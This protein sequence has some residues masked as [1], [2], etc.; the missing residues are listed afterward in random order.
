MRRYGRLPVRETVRIPSGPSGILRCSVND[1]SVEMD[2][3]LG[4]VW[5]LFVSDY[6]RGYAFKRESPARLRALMIPR[7]LT[8]S[9]LH[10]NL[11]IRLMVGTPRW[12]SYLWRRLLI[13][14]HAC[15]V[16]RD[17][18]IGP[19][20]ELP[21]PF[22]I[23]IGGNTRIGANVCIHHGVSIGP[24]RGRWIPGTSGDADATVVIE[25]GVVLFPYSQILAVNKRIGA[26]AEVGALQ[27]V[28]DDLP[29]G[30]RV[31][32]AGVRLPKELRP[33]QGLPEPQVPQPRRP[34]PQH[35][36]PQPT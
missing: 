29:P 36:E 13:S 11:L 26:G 18:T 14:H 3:G 22:G 16:A 8:N 6:E 17:I 12:T 30:A 20:L 24:V 2:R 35:P 27:I 15:D 28:T 4:N 10:A 31:T 7:M 32:R 5:R 23:A 19:G 21:H 34:E 1:S 9:S 33:E 25:D